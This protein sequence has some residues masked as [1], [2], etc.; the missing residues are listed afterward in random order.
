MHGNAPKTV[1]GSSCA[2]LNAMPCGSAG[3]HRWHGLRTWSQLPSY[4][5]L[6]TPAARRW[7]EDRVTTLLELAR[8]RSNFP[9]SLL[10]QTDPPQSHPSLNM[11]LLLALTLDSTHVST[12]A[13]GRMNFKSM[14]MRSPAGPQVCCSGTVWTRQTP[15]PKRPTSV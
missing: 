3:L 14:R 4:L 6:N 13:L 15:A 8:G 5:L 12:L 1:Q 9:G 10:V 7:P 2:G 11:L